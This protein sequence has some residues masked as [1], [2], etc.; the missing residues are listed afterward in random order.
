MLRRRSFQSEVKVDKALKV[1]WAGR[2]IAP[3]AS[4]CKCFFDTGYPQQYPHYNSKYKQG[5]NWNS[6]NSVW[7]SAYSVW[8]SRNSV[9]NSGNSVWNFAYSVWNSGNSVWNLAYSVWNLGDSVWNS[10]NSVWNFAY[11]VWRCEPSGI[12]FPQG[13]LKPVVRRRNRFKRFSLKPTKRLCQFLM[14]LINLA[15]SEVLTK[16]DRV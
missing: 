16:S 11:S 13:G 6:G 10:R 15:G 3:S 1:V 12:T 7:N 8:N 4:T 2:I 14:N 9:W 5:V